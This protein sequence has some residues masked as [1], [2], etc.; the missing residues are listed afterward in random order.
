MDVRC[1]L[2]SAVF[3]VR[4]VFASLMRYV[5]SKL[6]RITERL[7]SHFINVLLF[8]VVWKDPS[9]NVDRRCR[10]TLLLFG[11]FATNQHLYLYP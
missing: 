10:L 2:E 7:Q 5:G 1:E 6:R 9:G 8:W 11:R 4:C 3:G